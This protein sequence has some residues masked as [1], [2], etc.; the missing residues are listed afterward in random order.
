MAGDDQGPATSLSDC[1]AISRLACTA[2]VECGIV[3]QCFVHQCPRDW[4]ADEPTGAHP[5]QRSERR[6]S[7]PPSAH[8]GLIASIERSSGCSSLAILGE[9]NR[10]ASRGR[11]YGG[12][13]VSGLGLP[14]ISPTYTFWSAMYYGTRALATSEASARTPAQPVATGATLRA[15]RRLD[16]LIC[17]PSC[18]GLSPEVALEELV[19]G[20]RSP[21]LGA[22][23]SRA[24]EQSGTNAGQWLRRVPTLAESDRHVRET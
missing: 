15:L 8:P 19:D 18:V 10:Q 12:I 7:T 21:F 17:R 16:Q 6:K 14:A 1:V 22:E 13:A 5:R 9:S 23:P 24:R 2:R 11:T 3:S 4:K 20:A